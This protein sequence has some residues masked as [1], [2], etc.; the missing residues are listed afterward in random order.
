MT[1]NGDAVLVQLTVNFGPDYELAD[2]SYFNVALYYAPEE[3]NRATL[4]WNH[5]RMCSALG[6]GPPLFVLRHPRLRIRD[7]LLPLADAHPRAWAKDRVVLRART[8]APPH[9]AHVVAD[10]HIDAATPI[11]VGSHV[12]QNGDVVLTAKTLS[13]D[14]STATL[15][16]DV[17]GEEYY[18][19]DQPVGELTH[20]AQTCALL[21]IDSAATTFTRFGVGIAGNRKQLWLRDGRAYWP[22]DK[23]LTRLHELCDIVANTFDDVNADKGAMS[24]GDAAGNGISVRMCESQAARAL[25]RERRLSN[26][27]TAQAKTTALRRARAQGSRGAR[28]KRSQMAR[29]T[30]SS[31]R[32]SPIAARSCTTAPPRSQ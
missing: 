32:R 13:A 9:G 1:I 29:C 6:P 22:H 2:I 26:C 15:F 12:G 4:R 24:S 25:L 5:R 7:V 23:E 21:S 19:D 20:L 14:G 27:A 11:R 31:Q 30:T 10:L 18:L 28:W 16:Y 17:R 8:A 3:R